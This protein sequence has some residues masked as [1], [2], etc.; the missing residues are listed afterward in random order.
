MATTSAAPW[1]HVADI[2]PSDYVSP[3]RSMV[4]GGVARARI[5]EYLERRLKA[6]V[7]SH[8]GRPTLMLSGGIDSVTL[9][10]ALRHI[11]ADP[12]CVT[13]A[14]ASQ[15]SPDRERAAIVTRQLGLEHEIIE[16]TDGKIEQ[17]AA[18]CI[19]RIG[20]DELWE[21]GAA[22]PIRAVFDQ[23]SDKAG[24][25][26]SGA[27]ADVL[28]AGGLTLDAPPFTMAGRVE[29]RDKIW[30]NM[31]QSF[32]RERL[33]PDF[34]DRLLGDDARR[35]CEVFQTE[36]AW[37]MTAD[38]A[39]EVLYSTGPNGELVDKVCLRD[40]AVELGVDHSLVWAKKDPMQASSGIMSAFAASARTLFVNDAAA[41]TYSQPAREAD[42][43]ITARLWLRYIAHLKGSV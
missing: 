31:Q 42:S 15:P 32:C 24:A 27:G 25:V 21:I 10:A 3:E 33:I 35:F 1:E 16:L 26:V 5:L 38:F 2:L 7:T 36:E 22:I 8:Q 18:L 17:L 20:T 43:T 6:I 9:A 19:S 40:L 28:F 41:Q 4:D 12:L 37:H 29:L 30:D 11:D 14:A 34:F 39:P 13:V 23:I